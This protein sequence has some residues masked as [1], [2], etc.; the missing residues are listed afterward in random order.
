MDKWLEELIDKHVDTETGALNREDFTAEYS[1]EAPKQMVPKTVF[2]EKNEELKNANTTL[3][4]LSKTDNTEELKSQLEQYETKITD[5]EKERKEERK[6]LALK[7]ALKDTVDPEFVSTLLKDSVDYDEESGELKG[8]EEVLKEYKEKQPYLF[9]QA[10]ESSTQKNETVIPEVDNKQLTNPEGSV[11]T[12]GDIL[13]IKDR[14]E[15]LEA[16]AN[17][18]QLFK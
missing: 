16:I 4:E 13:G 9:N 8:M 17:N 3:E 1:T 6:V 14:T 15:R 5:L 12:K 18:K 2:N 7:G 11:L 10:D